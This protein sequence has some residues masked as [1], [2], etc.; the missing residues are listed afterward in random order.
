MRLQRRALFSACKRD[1]H[2]QFIMTR[3]TAA[4]IRMLDPYTLLAVLGK[5]VIRPGGRGSSETIYRM[6]GLQASRNV[7]DVGC[8]VGT[9]AIEIASRFGCRVTAVDIDNRMIEYAGNNIRRTGVADNITLRQGDIQAL[10]FPD[11][12]FDVV[13]IEAVSMFTGD[14]Q[15]SIREAVRVCKPGG[16]VFD[17]EFV[18]TIPPPANLRQVFDSMVC[19][20]I[21]FE[22]GREW[23]SLHQAAGQ[24]HI[25]VVPVPFD[26]L[27]PRGLLRDEGITGTAAFIGRTISRWTYI[28][29]MAW[30]IGVL[31]R[32]SPYLGSVVVASAKPGD[33]FHPESRRNEDAHENTETA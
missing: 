8:G 5:K 17:H 23:S 30:L 13:T 2:E 24:Q 26:V 12:S 16:Y 11:D 14:Q 3:L 20:G 22:T 7:L 21:S 25:Q 15:E 18:W 32:V 1:S 31:A 10:P 6:A 28:A 29:R 9:T 4:E 27:T 19:T 33:A